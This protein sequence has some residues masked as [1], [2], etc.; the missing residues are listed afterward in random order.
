MNIM[1]KTI[2]LLALLLFS[3]MTFAQLE[4]QPPRIKIDRNGREYTQSLS[5]FAIQLS[6]GG[7]LNYYDNTTKDYLGN[8]RGTSY[9][10]AL[11]YSDFYLG[12]AI[13]PIGK[14]TTEPTKEMNFFVTDPNLHGVSGQYSK[15]NVSLGYTFNFPLNFSIEPYVGYLNTSFN[16]KDEQGVEIDYLSKNVAGFTVGF[17][18]NK[19]LKLPGMGGF[20]VLYFT[21]NINYSDYSQFYAALGN[22]FYS[23]EL[24]I[25]IKGFIKV[26]N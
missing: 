4:K 21:N 8:Y 23:M 15:I 9:A 22:T 19:Y 12:L 11:Y 17:T 16:M 18:L 2:A 20:V 14:K 3:Q 26:K 24:G 10:L 5:A 6:L 1:N 13:K 25:A 7:S